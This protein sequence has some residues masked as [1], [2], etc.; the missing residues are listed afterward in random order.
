MCVISIKY[1]IVEEELELFQEGHVHEMHHRPLHVYSL[2][3]GLDP[4]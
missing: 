1:S 2:V 3:G 4:G